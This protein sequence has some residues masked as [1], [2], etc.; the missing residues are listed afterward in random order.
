MRTHGCRGW[1]WRGTGRTCCD[2]G[3]TRRPAMSEVVSTTEYVQREEHDPTEHAGNGPVVRSA[4]RDD[5]RAEHDRL[6]FPVQPGGVPIHPQ[7]RCDDHHNRKK[8]DPENHPAVRVATRVPPTHTA[9]ARLSTPRSASPASDVDA[10][11][12][13]MDC[14]QRCPRG[15]PSAE[16]ARRTTTRRHHTPRGRS[17]QRL[18]LT[19]HPKQ[20]PPTQRGRQS[21]I[22]C[23]STTVT[24]SPTS[25]AMV[26]RSGAAI[27]SLCVPSPSAMNELRKE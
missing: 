22:R 11:A 19:D 26:L 12:T 7:V 2:Q 27:G 9:S 8:R 20:A 25:F 1:P 16:S 14:R 18:V 15:K 4:Q 3:V 21:S 5:P 6:V 10:P 17:A 13:E 24:V 23:C